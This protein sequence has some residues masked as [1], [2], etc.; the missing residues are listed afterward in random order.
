MGIFQGRWTTYAGNPGASGETA[1][2]HK[3]FTLKDLAE[4]DRFWASQPILPESAGEETAG[5]LLAQVQDLCRVATRMACKIEPGRADRVLIKKLAVG[6]GSGLMPLALKILLEKV[7]P[8]VSQLPGARWMGPRLPHDILLRLESHPG[9]DPQRGRI[10]EDL[11]TAAEIG[12]WLA[13]GGTPVLEGLHAYRHNLYRYLSEEDAALPERVYGM[14]N[15]IPL[16]FVAREHGWQQTLEFL[17]GLWAHAW[18]MDYSVVLILRA[19]LVR[20][21]FK[22]HSRPASVAEALDIL[23]RELFLPYGAQ[24]H[25]VAPL[26]E[27]LAATQEQIDAELKHLRHTSRSLMEWLRGIYALLLPASHLVHS[28]HGASQHVEPSLV[29]DLQRRFRFYEEIRADIAGCIDSSCIY[30]PYALADEVRMQR[31]RRDAKR[32][33]TFYCHGRVFIP[34]FI[35]PALE[36]IMD[37]LPEWPPPEASKVLHARFAEELKPWIAGGFIH[38]YEML[39]PQDY[40]AR[41]LAR[42]ARWGQ[43]KSSPEYLA[44]PSIGRSVASALYLTSGMRIPEGETGLGGVPPEKVI[45]SP[46]EENERHP[47]VTF[48]M[49][50]QGYLSHA[51][52]VVRSGVSAAGPAYDAAGA[53]EALIGL[54]RGVELASLNEF[55][56]ERFEL[57]L[58][59]WSGLPMRIAIELEQSKVAAIIPLEVPPQPPEAARAS[60]RC[61]PYEM[62]R[63]MTAFTDSLFRRE[64]KPLFLP[65]IRMGVPSGLR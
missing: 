26:L 32:A 4:V 58:I 56:A 14:A 50:E 7:Y 2:D 35:V 27:V 24:G 30:V 13:N 5:E 37:A 8:L 54:L 40:R 60:P 29:P 43:L 64:N 11:Y 51:H 48:A 46:A 25:E 18:L 20:C 22:E 62:A 28:L 19:A 6:R 42:E 3:E 45:L 41:K 63:V 16:G 47:K 12:G 65:S 23:R 39:Y 44:L 33:L 53:A 34:L 49:D 10:P 1:H 55:P 21:L 17:D 36:K 52:V 31:T 9:Y 38:A 59:D 15:V 57:V 61:N